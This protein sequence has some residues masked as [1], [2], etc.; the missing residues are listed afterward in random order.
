MPLRMQCRFLTVDGVDF[1]SHK[2]A[3]RAALLDAIGKRPVT[4]RVLYRL[5]DAGTR[6]WYVQ[7]SID[8][9]T[10]FEPA[11]AASREAGVMGLDFNARGVAW[12]AVK[13][14][15]NRVRDQHGFFTWSL[16]GSTDSERKQ[17]IGMVV[18]HLARHAKRLKL[19][20]AIEAL[21]FATKKASARAGAVNKR[22][23]DMLGSLPSAQ[24][25][26]LML[27]A[28]EKQHL[29]LY[30]VNPLFS[31]VGGFTKYG[32]PN[33][34]NADTSAAL[35]LGRQALYGEVWKT[36]GA[37]CNVGIFDERL[38]F[39]HLPAT[40]MQSMT[41]LAGAQWRD[42]ARG[43]GK[44]RKL[45]GKK[46]HSWFLCQVEAASRSKEQPALASLPAG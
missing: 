3:A 26:D 40:P 22:Y 28:C 17:E 39:S 8:V 2:G 18:A 41:A 25:E 34:M 1:V 33:R 16:K 5:Q 37:Q 30:S 45:W 19:P 20:M 4:M 24:F 21:D 36:E 32:R 10:G 6:A 42:V 13:P 12:C 38:V 29:K 35:W 7:A 11:T 15:G 14:D 46:F 44:N 27:R 43:L 9:P 31:S 23:N